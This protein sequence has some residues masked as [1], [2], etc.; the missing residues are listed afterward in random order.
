[1]RISREE[2]AHNDHYETDRNGGLRGGLRFSFPDSELEK[3]HKEQKRC[4]HKDC[5][6]SYI[7]HWLSFHMLGEQRGPKIVEQHRTAQS[8][9]IDLEKKSSWVRHG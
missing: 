3:Y 6:P 7:R 9:A 4:C 1:M 8:M 2:H 5:E